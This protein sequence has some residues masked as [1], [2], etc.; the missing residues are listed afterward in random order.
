MKKYVIPTVVVIAVVAVALAALFLVGRGGKEEDGGGGQAADGAIDLGR[1]FSYYETGASYKVAEGKTQGSFRSGQ[2]ADILLSGVDFN[3]A[4]G[5]LLFNHP[6]NLASDG[7]RL[8]LADRNNN[9]VLIWNTLPTGNRE[10][11]L[12]L[13]QKDF[14]T[15]EPGS[16]LDG[17]NWPVGV[18]TDGTRLLVADTYNDRVLVWN[19]FPSSN[20]Q[21]ADYAIGKLDDLPPM[22][23]GSRSVEWPWAVWTDG[24]KLIVASTGNGRVLIWNRFP[25]DG[26]TRPDILLRL[27]DKFGT[28]R[29]IG[30][31]GERLIIGDHN[32][33]GTNRGNFFWRSFPVRDNQE[34]DFYMAS[35]VPAPTQPGQ[36]QQP[37][38]TQQQ[39]QPSQPGQPQ[40]P[41]QQGPGAHPGTP[42][43]GGVVP[44][45]PQGGPM[46]EI[47]WGPVFTPEG[48]LLVLGGD[49]RIG[50]WN[51]FPEDASD[52]PDLVIG[53]GSGPQPA[54]GPV[55]ASGQESGGARVGKG[56][57]FEGGDGSSMA[58]AGE[59]L[60]LSLCNGNKIVGFKALPSREDQEPDFAVGSPD[61]HTN[62]LETEF[63]MSNPNP[64]SDGEHLFV[65]SDFDRRLYV[66]RHLP[67]ESGAEPDLVY[68]LPDEPW[69]NELHGG[70]LALAGKRSVYIWKT[71]P[72]EPR[73]PDIIL[74][75]RIGN[76]SLQELKGVALDDRYF[77]LA[78]GAAGKIYVWEGL[79]SA[80]ANPVM[81]VDAPGGLTRLS[82]DGEFLAAVMTEAQGGGDVYLYR[83]AELQ[84]GGR[85]LSLA[86]TVNMNLPQGAA[87][88]GG[89]LFLCDTNYSRVF[90]WED[91]E[92]AARGEK[93]DATL[94]NYGENLPREALKPRIGKASLFW[95]ACAAF[96]G[97]YLWLG[98]FKF[99][100]RLLRFS[101]H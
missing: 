39:P 1:G 13:G 64:A 19:T 65:S 38:Q 27:R 68:N 57:K 80:D 31:D 98:E 96:D 93:P 66:Y 101:P 42:P 56:Y 33:F 85:P 94:G 45:S 79:P 62:T 72:L 18:A 100:E 77:Y 99:S 97:T 47:F 29:S 59:S 60:Y 28:P 74:E 4:G 9:R 37:G 75:D 35:L 21:P 2:E 89:K 52:Y 90:I 78:D 16:G 30:C 70:V 86:R 12:V 25:A 26:R 41:P 15:N 32:A 83:V 69:D 10:P 20:G 53:E 11:D 76:V 8:I 58:L 81:T 84:G 82:S 34:P 51:K 3:N 49:Y 17:M 36:P 63:I 40:Q 67:G 46:G 95:P 50:I 22:D 48:R 92:R 44:V 61:I 87:L 24:Q 88:A 43:G 23:D 5:G 6:G 54:A 55:V 71:L 7:T 14:T 91:V 73:L